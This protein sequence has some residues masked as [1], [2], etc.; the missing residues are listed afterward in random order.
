MSQYALRIRRFSIYDR[1]ETEKPNYVEETEQKRHN[2]RPK[3]GKEERGAS[4]LMLLNLA[5]VK[6][7]WHLP[8][9]IIKQLAPEKGP[10]EPNLV[11]PGTGMC[12][13]GPWKADSGAR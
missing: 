2:E 8:S 4:G 13:G 5:F 6:F 9:L 10:G 7:T 12:P 3:Q 1:I 11:P